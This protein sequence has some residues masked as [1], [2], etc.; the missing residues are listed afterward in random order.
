LH[1]LIISQIFPPDLGGSATRA[2]N[3]GKGLLTNGSKVTVI[4]GFPHYPTGNVPKE[5]RSKA[6]VT[7]YMEGMKVI[8]TF[9][10]PIASKGFARRLALFISFIIS[11]LFPLLL[12][13]KIDGVF[14]SNPHLLSIFPAL[15]YKIFHRCPTI[16]N[17]DDLWPENLYDLGMLK[18]ETS[19]KVSEF[20]AKIAYS[21]ADAITP[22]SPAY[23]GII[24]NKYEIEESKVT[25]IPGGVDLSTFTSDFDA[26]EEN[27][28]FKVLYI[29]AFSPAYDFE[30]VLRAA[31][32]LEGRDVKIVLQGSGEAASMIRKRMKAL[33]IRNVELIEKVVS[34][35]EVAKIMASSDALL[36][37]LSGME[38]VEKGISSKLY[39]Y[40]A[41]GKPIISCSSGM[42]AKYVEE[43]RSGVV[44]KPGD[45]E[46]LAKAILYL[47]ENKDVAKSLG[48]NGRRYVEN[49]M[50][51]EKIGSKMKKLFRNFV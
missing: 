7:E 30:Q 5:Y 36:L 31:K 40:Q 44:V 21:L 23:V 10:P 19:K 42:P 17:V 13:E 41:S 38:N 35:K 24:V 22:I 33:N 45:Y 34:R 1:V 6:I 37:P 9:V 2:Y 50:S 4:A 15:V 8:R 39:E 27:G 26:I 51:I 25:V 16:L 18:S 11:S 28:E 46:A 20:V 3:L 12:I 29:G 43:T 49:N 14:A 47:K 48:E 32:L